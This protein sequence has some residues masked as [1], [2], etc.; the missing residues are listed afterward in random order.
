[1]HIL[2][3][4]CQDITHFSAYFYHLQG[5]ANA[6]H[7]KGHSVSILCPKTHNTL[8]V[9]SYIKVPVDYYKIPRFLRWTRFFNPVLAMIPFSKQL[10]KPVD[11]VYIRMSPL[12]FILNWMS[13][14]QDIRTISEH[15]GLL[16]D[17]IRLL[18]PAFSPIAAMFDYFQRLN[19][20]YS[21]AVRAVSQNLRTILFKKT[22][23]PHIVHITNGTDTNHFKPMNR[24]EAL[25]RFGLDPEKS[26]IGFIG[27]LIKT[28]GLE[29]AIRSFAEFWEK[30]PKTHLLI[31]GFGPE[32]D[33]LQELSKQLG[34][35][36]HVTFLGH[37][38][39]EYAP[40]VINCFDVAISPAIRQRNEIVGLATMKVRDYLACGRLI[41]ASRLPGYEFL[42]EEGLGMLFEPE[43]HGD[44]IGS[45]NQ[46][47]LMCSVSEKTRKYSMNEFSWTRIVEHIVE[48]ERI[49]I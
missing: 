10:R 25:Q 8:N 45:L 44:F 37:I 39:Y 27:T 14:R 30:H 31:A 28:Q 2:L 18:Y 11:M 32:L 20:R 35:D 36:D 7:E 43:S 46:S 40:V 15:N 6:F 16:G 17:E 12:S 22:H 34:M 42:E 4:S 13:Y 48:L 19:I 9:Q 41:V 38:S 33:S 47:I 26:Y 3:V 49:K 29:F 5:V 1:M 23:H 21:H 24:S